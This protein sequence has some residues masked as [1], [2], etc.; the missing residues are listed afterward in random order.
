[1]K[2]LSAPA[3]SAATP[4]TEKLAAFDFDGTLTQG[5]TLLP[6]LRRGLGW[7]GFVWALLLSA[8]WL[9]AYACG[10]LSNQRAKARLL[11]VSLG[12]RSEV[13][14]ERWSADFVTHY[15]PQQWNNETLQR[16]RHHQRLGHCCVIVSASPGI[17]LHRVAE[18]LG[19]D[20][21]IC[22]EL[23]VAGGALTG[24]MRT[25]N[26]YGAEK[27]RRLQAWRAGRGDASAPTTL[28]AYGDS[29]GDVA[30]LNL[31]DWAWYQGRPWARK[32]SAP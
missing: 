2:N 3:A 23:E 4:P 7:P 18:V 30:L 16:L 26:C 15:L 19:L 29:R 1:M 25:A 21:A 14:I 12:G 6:Y 8:P 28:Y 13:E 22:T 20:A 24:Q 31:A 10:L 32:T 9:A 11:Q 17:Y 5:D 27:V